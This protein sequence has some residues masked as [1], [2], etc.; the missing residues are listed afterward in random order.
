MLLISLFMKY[1]SFPTLTSMR[2]QLAG[3][4][5]KPGVNIEV[6]NLRNEQSEA[7]PELLCSTTSDIPPITLL[8]EHYF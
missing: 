7:A 6:S 8:E 4:L 1:I 3:N 5:S 2:K